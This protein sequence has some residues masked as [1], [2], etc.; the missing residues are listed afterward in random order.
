LA[1]AHLGGGS[2]VGRKLEESANRLTE[3]HVVV[4]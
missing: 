1:I 3:P 2:N 4:A